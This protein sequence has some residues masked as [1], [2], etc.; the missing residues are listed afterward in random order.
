MHRLRRCHL[1]LYLR[2]SSSCA[3]LIPPVS[4]TIPR[5]RAEHPNINRTESRL[6]TACSVTRAGIE[7]RSVEAAPCSDDGTGVRGGGAVVLPRVRPEVDPPLPADAR[8]RA[9][10]RGGGSAR[11]GIPCQRE[12][13]QRAPAASVWPTHAAGTCQPHRRWKVQ[14]NRNADQNGLFG[15]RQTNADLL[16]LLF[17]QQSPNRLRFYSAPLLPSLVGGPGT[18]QD[19]VRVTA[20][21]REKIKKN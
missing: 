1:N 14:A 6:L 8:H 17:G 18:C 3:L 16:R 9:I 2:R 7:S 15:N 4:G 19:M 13:V 20:N 21:I 12:S 10:A 11:P 5:S